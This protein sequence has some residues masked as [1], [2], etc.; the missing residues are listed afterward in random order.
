MTGSKRRKRS[1]IDDETPMIDLADEV[2]DHDE[3]AL[4]RTGEQKPW[5]YARL[6]KDLMEAAKG[7]PLAEVPEEQG[8]DPVSAAMFEMLTPDFSDRA[9][10]STVG[11]NSRL[12]R[13]AVEAADDYAS[14]K[15]EQDRLRVVKERADADYSA[16]TERVNQI[17]DRESD[18][19]FGHPK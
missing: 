19:L 9:K 18:R 7:I 15:A 1:I 5:A 10:R 13:E 4:F 2:L 14:A 12:V 3:V 17:W 6:D 16:A 11:Y 8:C